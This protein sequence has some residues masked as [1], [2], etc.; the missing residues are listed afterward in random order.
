MITFQNQKIVVQ[1][2]A[3]IDN[4]TALTRQGL[5]L[6]SG[7]ACTVDLSQLTEVDSTVISMFL[8]WSRAAQKM[9]CTLCF[10]NMPSSVAGLIQL[11]GMTELISVR[12]NSA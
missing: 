9:G 5:P 12:K 6:L 7:S 2:H 10:I 1:G 3:T 4:V 11:Y 8:E